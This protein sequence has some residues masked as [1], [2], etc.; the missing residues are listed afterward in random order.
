[1]NPVV[2]GALQGAIPTLVLVG[3]TNLIVKKFRE[4]KPVVY[5][6]SLAVAT[7]LTYAVVV[8]NIKVPFMNAEEDDLYYCSKCDEGFSSINPTDEGQFCDSC[9]PSSA[10][11]HDEME[12]ITMD[13]ETFEAEKLHPGLYRYKG[14]IGLRK[15]WTE[16]QEC[17]DLVRLNDINWYYLKGYGQATVCDSCVGKYNYKKDRLSKGG[18]HGELAILQF[19]EQD[20]KE[21]ETFE[22]YGRMPAWM[23]G[24]RQWNENHLVWASDS[25]AVREAIKTAFPEQKFSVRIVKGQYIEVVAKSGTRPA[26]IEQFK[27]DVKRV[28]M[29]VLGEIYKDSPEELREKSVYVQ[30]YERDFGAETFNAELEDCYVCDGMFKQVYVCDNDCGFQCCEMDIDGN[31][32]PVENADGTVKDYCIT[33]YEENYGAET[34]ESE[35]DCREAKEEVKKLRR[36]IA[37]LDKLYDKEN[38]LHHEILG[39]GG[40]FKKHELKGLFSEKDLK[41]YEYWNAE[42]FSAESNLDHRS[43]NLRELQKL[44]ERELSRLA[45]DNYKIEEQLKKLERGTPKEYSIEVIRDLL[46]DMHESLGAINGYGMNYLSLL[47]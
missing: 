40:F 8:G 21:A 18:Q 30:A 45:E 3:G 16:C 7:G 44:L 35:S 1:M 12:R 11:L 24:K 23:R 5:W 10:T 46:S 4:S 25:K 38:A 31:L 28:A 34:F 13:A 43:A 2:K 15:G 22:A 20:R 32:I 26:D 14:K 42:T 19:M 17:D 9:L 41:N 29:T 27:E 39:S 33:C 6:G 47:Q 37:L 36:K